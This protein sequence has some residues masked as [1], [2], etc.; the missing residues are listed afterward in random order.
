MSAGSMNKSMFV[1]HFMVKLSSVHVLCYSALKKPKTALNR[2]KDEAVGHDWS[3]MNP[4]FD[5]NPQV[6]SIFEL[7]IHMSTDVHR[8]VSKVK[9]LFRV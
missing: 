6:S 5:N 4:T 1:H 9:V 8:K 2:F 7:Y 3:F